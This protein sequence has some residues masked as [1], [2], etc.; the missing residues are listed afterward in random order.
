MEIVM[1]VN[2]VQFMRHGGVLSKLLTMAVG[3]QLSP[4]ENK[5]RDTTQT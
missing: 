5:A 2:Y 3:F 1:G 4:Q